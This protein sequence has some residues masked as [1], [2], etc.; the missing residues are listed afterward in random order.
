MCVSWKW[1]RTL[2][3]LCRYVNKGINARNRAKIVFVLFLL[4]KRTFINT[5]SLVV[6]AIDF[7][8]MEML[9]WMNLLAVFNKWVCV[10]KL[11]MLWSAF[12]RCTII[13]PGQSIA[14]DSTNVLSNN[15]WRL[16]RSFCEIT[17]TRDGSQCDR[18]VTNHMNDSQ[19][20]L[21]LHYC[22][23]KNFQGKSTETV[24]YISKI[25][26][27]VMSYTTLV[28]LWPYTDCQFLSQRIHGTTFI[29][30]SQYFTLFRNKLKAWWR[31]NVKH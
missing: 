26:D 8:A 5:S 24:A 4:W 20:L 17:T 19:T 9:F 6:T 15:N 27:C 2:P 14:H 18:F 31:N 3:P 10:P 30:I 1:E 12:W 22:E 25:S 13:R 29:C 16:V 7:N 28:I 11:I 23:A 21:L